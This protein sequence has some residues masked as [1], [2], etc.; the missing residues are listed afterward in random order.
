[1]TGWVQR[2]GI[3][4]LAVTAWTAPGSGE[5]VSPGGPQGS[6]QKVAAAAERELPQAFAPEPLV[7]P[8]GVLPDADAVAQL[9]AHAARRL[10]EKLAVI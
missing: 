5:P 9:E 3:V 2:A 4:L 1:M 7:R 8:A 10:A 6:A